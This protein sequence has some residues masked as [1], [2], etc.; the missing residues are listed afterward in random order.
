M[1]D[2]ISAA[3]SI[4]SMQQEDD[5]ATLPKKVIE[6][7]ETGT[8]ESTE[9][10]ETTEGHSEVLAPMSFEDSTTNTSSPN[11]AELCSQEREEVVGTNSPGGGTKLPSTVPIPPNTEAEDE[12]ASDAPPLTKAFRTK[13][14]FEEETVKRFI[15]AR[16]IGSRFFRENPPQELPVFDTD[17]KV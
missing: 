6:Q 3:E 17:G 8:S 7:P 11:K 10:T 13:K 4:A 2:A 5:N 16:T 15:L 12:N 9:Q 1:V 14:G